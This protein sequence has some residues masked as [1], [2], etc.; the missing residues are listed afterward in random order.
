MEKAVSQ[1]DQC[2]FC[3]ES[4]QGEPIPEESRHLYGG[5][6]HYSLRITVQITG[7]YDGGLYYQ[8]PSCGFAWNRWPEGDPLHEKAETY[9]LE[10]NKFFSREPPITPEGEPS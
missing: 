8:C 2:P 1:P 9:I 7:V 5:K 6:T 10:N 4:L 3:E